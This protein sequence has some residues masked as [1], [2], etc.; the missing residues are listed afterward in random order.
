MTTKQT[1]DCKSLSNSTAQWQS[2]MCIY[3]TQQSSFHLFMPIKLGKT[4]NIK[5][6][7]IPFIIYNKITWCYFK[8]LNIQ[9]PKG[10]TIRIFSRNSFY[11]LKRFWDII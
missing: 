2:L 3:E 10:F 11:P 8:V 7:N 9:V 6:L 4:I 1:D 5:L